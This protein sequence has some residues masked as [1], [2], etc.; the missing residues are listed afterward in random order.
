MSQIALILLALAITAESFASSWNSGALHASLGERMPGAAA[1]ILTL[2]RLAM[3]LAGVFIGRTI[4]L[5][6]YDYNIQF[7][8]V[9]IIVTGLK[10][11]METF[12]FN[13]EAKIVL[14]DN[15]KTVWLWSFAGSFNVF[16][17]GTGSGLAGFVLYVALILFF[18]ST[19]AGSY[20]GMWAGRKNGFRKWIRNVVIIAGI[21]IIVISLRVLI[22]LLS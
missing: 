15:Y 19:L 6:L 17:I 13:H 22:S 10:M 9:L 20:V 11:L 5:L 4:S 12:R 14:L 21:L 18:I 1:P 8:L 16:L 2:V 3:L 7:G